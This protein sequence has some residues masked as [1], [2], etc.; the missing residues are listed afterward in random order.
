MPD[1]YIAYHSACHTNHHSTA[2]SLNGTR[3]ATPN[4]TTQCNVTPCA[5]PAKNQLIHSIPVHR[6]TR[7]HSSTLH[8]ATT[9]HNKTMQCNATQCNAM[10][11][12]ETRSVRMKRWSLP[13]PAPW[14]EMFQK[15]DKPAAVWHDVM[16]HAAQHKATQHKTS[17]N[18]VIACT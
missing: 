12:N 13:L 1:H 14:L 5:V 9:Q 4:S 15:G 11:R 16:Q 7:R 6:T 17:P 10:E 2:H 8:R 18:M 3:C